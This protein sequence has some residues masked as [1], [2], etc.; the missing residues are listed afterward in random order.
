MGG[1]ALGSPTRLTGSLR[2]VFHTLGTSL[3]N[4]MCTGQEGR[5]QL[6]FLL[7]NFNVTK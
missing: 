7:L 3:V 6:L 5:R 1:V 4:E 2:G